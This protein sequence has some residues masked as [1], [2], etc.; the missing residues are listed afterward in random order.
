MYIQGKET[1]EMILDVVR[2]LWERHKRTERI[3]K[4]MRM[5]KRCSRELDMLLSLM[6]ID[7]SRIELC[8]IPVETEENVHIDERR[9]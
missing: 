9:R 5:T 7:Y 4:Q 3:R 8:P 1:D 2:A 6:G